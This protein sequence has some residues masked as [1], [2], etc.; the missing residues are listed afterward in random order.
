[1]AKSSGAQGNRASGKATIFDNY[2]IRESESYPAFSPSAPLTG[3]VPST[4]T[5]VAAPS[6][7]SSEVG[8]DRRRAVSEVG[9]PSEFASPHEGRKQFVVPGKV[10]RK[11][12]A[13]WIV[14]GMG[15]QV[16]FETVDSLT[17][18]L[19]RVANI[20]GTPPRFRTVTLGTQTMQRVELDV[21]DIRRDA[22]GNPLNRYELHLY[23][24]Y[25]APETE[26]VAKL[27]D[28]VSFLLDGGSRGLLN[29][30][31]RF[32][33]AMF[34]EM[35]EFRILFRTAAYICGTLLILLALA[36]INGVILAAAA[37]R[38][39]LPVLAAM[40]VASYWPQLTVLASLMTGVAFAFG[41]VLF[42]AEMSRSGNWPRAVRLTLSIVTWVAL[43][44]TAAV[45]VCT[46]FV[47]ALATDTHRFASRLVLMPVTQ[48]QPFATLLILGCGLLVAASMAWRGRRRSSGQVLRANGTLLFFF[49]LSFLLFLGSLAVPIWLIGTALAGHQF[50]S[51]L[52][53][54]LH[55]AYWPIR[56]ASSSVWVWSFLIALS[57]KIRTLL[58]EYAGDVAIYVTPNKLDRFDEV[59]TKIKQT[60]RD[61]ASAI[62][63]AVDPSNGKFVY[64][65]VAAVGHSLGSVI[66]YDTL[67]R[68][69]LDDGL[70]GNRL[71]IANRTNTFVTFGSPLD[72][73]AFL[74]TIQ[75]KETYH[76]RERL[77]ATVQPLIQ[78]YKE[79]RPFRWIN[80][81]SRN[82]V[83]SGKL[84][85]YDLRK[86]QEPKEV[87]PKAV[88]NVV[89]KDAS[90]PLVAHV[91]YW[92]NNLVWRELIQRIAPGA[93]VRPARKA[94]KP[95]KPVIPPKDR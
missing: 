74:F 73:T 80:V 39:K 18:G 10:A 15:Q 52:P 81:Y 27:Q 48:L 55:W 82:D 12:R 71:R 5:P 23:E 72:K 1:M 29:C 66:A 35:E 3:A 20:A 85:F 16:P 17:Q 28:V 41:T 43:L 89:D 91:D 69:M 19:V 37:A 77:A 53:T 50:S 46:A 63:L 4:G 87:P 92:K 45:I 61:V 31:H 83:F 42:L 33:R 24:A 47:M 94:P 90:V 44:A 22:H 86:M 58:V 9:A 79:F 51:A 88:H 54:S 2:E 7:R 14:H 76:V 75:G 84:V 68:L 78:N 65:Q 49:A 21:D 70:G 62:Y 11:K 56:I 59:R 67:N 26:G 38:E 60:V 93:Y 25:W 57:A 13:I 40:P 6:G 30:R 64:E 36:V 8:E 34:G 95:P 32:Q